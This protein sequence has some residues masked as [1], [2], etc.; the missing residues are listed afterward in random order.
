[1]IVDALYSCVLA[2]SRIIETT[3]LGG[4][5]EGEEN[6][7]VGSFI[8]IGLALAIQVPLAPF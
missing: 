2:K 3:P 4:G 8:E 6:C 1:M 5:L 7:D